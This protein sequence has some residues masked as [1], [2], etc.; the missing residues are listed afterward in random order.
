MKGLI[1]IVLAALIFTSSV[2][3]YAQQPA[4]VESAVNV[5]VSKYDDIDG[6]SCM[7][8]GKGSGLNMVKSMFN[9]Q[10]GKS[11]MKGVTSITIIEYS[12]AS[13]ETC[14]ALRNDMDIF[15]SLLKEFDISKEKQFS[16]NKFL[17]CFASEAESG[18]LTD[19]V[20][21]IENDNSKMF[22]YM[23]GK[24]KVE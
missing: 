5:M 4:N 16:D 7:T 21:A 22:M 14:T 15:L 6:V 9:K 11:F 20:I 8:V 1:K 18:T 17:R 19:F 12:D 3:V 10:F 23:A 13:E 2:S 24:I